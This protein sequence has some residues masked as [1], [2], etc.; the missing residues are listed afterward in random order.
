MEIP[1]KARRVA[2]KLLGPRA[3]RYIRRLLRRRVHDVDWYLSLFAGRQGLEIGGPSEA[4]GV[5]GPIPVYRVLRCLDNCLFS[6]Q[7]IWAGQTE[8]GKHF[9]FNSLRPSGYQFV[10]EGTEL[11]KIPDSSYDCVLSSHSLEHIA[12][13]LLALAEWKRISRKDGIL[14]LLLPH[15][16]RTFDW[17]RPTTNLAHMIEDRNR[18]TKED[19]LT[20]L[21]EILTLHDLRKDKAA[22][23]LEHFRS[24]CMDN[25]QYRAM[26]HHVFDTSTAVEMLD[27]AGFQL[28]RV[29][30]LKPCHIILVCQKC[31]HTP[32]NAAF[33]AQDAEYR[34]HS[35]FP[36]DRPSAKLSRV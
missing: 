31:D 6:N 7:T 1:S 25:Y 22:G 21:E 20:H 32:E 12:N 4:F 18:G 30:L 11:R 13:P 17:R 3:A 35:P 23:S 5:E 28:L 33:L 16:D 34:R 26:H 36:S 24:R 29:D 27:Y 9:K 19:D 8:E 10:L 2:R 14:L 15:K